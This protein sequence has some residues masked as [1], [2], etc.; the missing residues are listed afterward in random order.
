MD[1]DTWVITILIL[2]VIYEI[3]RHKRNGRNSKPN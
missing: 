3:R 1:L 2:A